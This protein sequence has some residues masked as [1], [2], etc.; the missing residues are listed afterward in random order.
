M[1]SVL[2]GKGKSANEVRDVA[3]VSEVTVKNAYKIIW[4]DKEKLVDPRW[5]EP[6]K[7]SMVWLQG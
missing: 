4:A 2:A 3:S 5:I 7:G 6:R 1:P